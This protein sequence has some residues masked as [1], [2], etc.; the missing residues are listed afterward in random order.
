MSITLMNPTELAGQAGITPR[1]ARFSSNDTLATMTT[2]GYITTTILNGWPLATGD[3]AFVSSTVSGT[4]TNYAFKVLVAAT[5]IY[6]LVSI[7]SAL[8]GV[9]VAGH[10]PSFLDSEG[11]LVDLGYLP[12]NASLTEVVM[13]SGASVVGHIAVYADTSGT[14][15]DGGAFGFQPQVF[16]VTASHTAL[17]TA[18]TV[19]AIISSGSKQFQILEIFTNKGGTNFS[20]GGGDRL[21]QIT[22]G[23]TVYTVI[24]ATNIQ[25][26]INSGWGATSLPYPA[27]AA[28]DT[29]TVAGTD[30][31]I[32]YS[33]GTTDYTAG[34]ISLTIVAIEIA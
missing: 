25:T 10:F 12:T 32:S 11:D 28:I 9:A 33:G 6:T 15:T 23:T 26:I 29:A 7:A 21:L 2:A 17:A 22:D 14:I 19:N 5:G 27:S 16:N 34:S 8:Q 20:G 24:P 4:T 18:G 13:Q 30:L 31:V 1:L 3:F